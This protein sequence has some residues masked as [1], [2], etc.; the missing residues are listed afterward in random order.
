MCS[1]YFMFSMFRT[2]SSILSL[3]S[4]LNKGA[5]NKTSLPSPGSPQCHGRDWTR[6]QHTGHHL[7]S[8]HD[9][10]RL[11]DGFLPFYYIWMCGYKWTK[12]QNMTTALSISFSTGLFKETNRILQHPLS[13]SVA[14]FTSGTLNSSVEMASSRH[15]STTS[16]HSFRCLQDCFA[17]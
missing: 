10:P 3:L 12:K 6:L 7:P 14:F 1:Y 15:T 9:A 4:R 17:L 8:P 13:Q 11:T 16:K 2:I 5:L